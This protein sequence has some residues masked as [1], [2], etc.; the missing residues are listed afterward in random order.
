M[1]FGFCRTESAAGLLSSRLDD[2]SNSDD[3]RTLADA[4]GSLGST[5]AW[6]AMGPARQ[7]EAGRVRLRAVDA[8]HRALP[9]V[10]ASGRTAVLEA[11]RMLGE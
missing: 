11:L 4:L 7:A 5:W 3:V 10:D 6:Q 8:L 2:A 1:V 9:R